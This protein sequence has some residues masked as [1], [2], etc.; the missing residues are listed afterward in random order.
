MAPRLGH[1]PFI[2]GWPWS[3]YRSVFY[4]GRPDLIRSKTRPQQWEPLQSEWRFFQ[5]F[6]CYLGPPS[7]VLWNIKY[8]WLFVMAITTM[9]VIW[10]DITTRTEEPIEWD[11]HEVLKSTFRMTSFAMSLL[12]AFRI[13]RTYDR[14]REARSS[15]SGVG[16]GATTL[17]L[18]A[19]TW[20]DDPDIVEDFRRFCIV[21]P[22]SIK[23]TVMS[24]PLDPEAAAL[25]HPAELEVY[26]KSRKGRQ[27]VVT[28]VRKLAKEAN[29]SMEQFMSM[30]TVIQATWKSAGDALRIK[31]QAMPEG[32]TLMCTGFVEIWCLLLPFGLIVD[33]GHL[34]WVV[35][36][37]VAVA[38]LLLLGCDEVA[39]QME[40]PFSLMPVDDIVSTYERDINRIQ[41]EIADISAAH[42]EARRD[43]AHTR[44]AHALLEA[45]KAAAH[46]HVRQLSGSGGADRS[47]H[48]RSSNGG[49]GSAVPGLPVPRSR[50]AAH[51]AAAAATA[52]APGNASITTPLLGGIGRSDAGIGA[53]A[54]EEMAALGARVFTCSRNAEELEAALGGWK[55][56]GYDVQGCVAD[57]SDAGQRA[58]LVEAVSAAFGGQLHVLVNNVGINIRKPTVEYTSQEYHTLMSTNLESAFVLCQLCQP[59]LAS[60]GS[61]C[62]IFNSSVAGGPT[63]M[64][65]GTIYAMTKASLNQLTKNLA[66]EWAVHGIRVNSVAPWYTATPL[67][68][69]VLKDETFKAEVLAR[70]PM[71]RIGQPQ[72][73]AGLMAFLAS[74]AASYVTGQTIAV[75]GGYS[76]AGPI[77]G[78]INGRTDVIAAVA[79]NP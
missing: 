56:K 33:T 52:A 28:A 23:H 29:L 9:L 72:E 65:S 42:L 19:A 45:A 8:P 26:M 50:G 7:H 69:Q 35:L 77:L 59:L 70:T 30:E 48:G 78:S 51:P 71:R 43:R 34:D 10:A 55:A 12:L 24:T 44:E 41:T 63:A 53:A 46:A 62:I 38:S 22:Y 57:V 66:C 27:V 75:D 54:V 31:F 32:V 61:S 4:D 6:F 2:L 21:W 5:A 1:G 64:W 47:H 49:S 14:W 40:Q 58:A 17:F 36:I 15:L 74:P 79:K 20:I 68:N 76:H 60:A 13:N 3:L 67:A 16:T 37:A 39:N 25:L 73:V 18:Q 11:R